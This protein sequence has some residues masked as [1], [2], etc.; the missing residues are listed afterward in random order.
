MPVRAGGAGA[1]KVKTQQTNR[2]LLF[3]ARS[4]TLS[5]A[6]L[7][8]VL[9]ERLA[10]LADRSRRSGAARVS[11]RPWSSAPEG[12]EIRCLL[13]QPQNAGP[14][15]E[16]RPGPAVASKATLLGAA[17]RV[18][19]GSLV[20]TLKPAED[21]EK[22][23]GDAAVPGP[24]VVRLGGR[25]PNRATLGECATRSG[26]QLTIMNEIVP[27]AIGNGG[28]APCR[29]APSRTS[30]G[31]RS[32]IEFGAAFAIAGLYLN[33]IGLGTRFGLA[34][35]FPSIFSQQILKMSQNGC[36]D[37]GLRLLRKL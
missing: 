5:L 33:F 25:M 27:S 10:H 24:P 2:F 15:G 17:D 34:P 7:S 21:G 3:A 31:F 18:W 8:R 4:Q 14:E 36:S 26:K 19:L 32:C 35:E 12:P 30:L 6:E 9:G 22:G 16:I 11:H 13:P 37:C 29:R 23:R 1:E 20:A 28:P